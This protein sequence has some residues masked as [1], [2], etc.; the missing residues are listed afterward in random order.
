MNNNLNIKSQL[1][2]TGV[3]DIN[4]QIGTINEQLQELQNTK[5]DSKDIPVIQD[6][7]LGLNK[8]K[9]ALLNS[10]LE[11]D[12]AHQE[13]MALEAAKSSDKGLQ[14]IMVGGKS[15]LVPKSLAIGQSAYHKPEVQWVDENR[16]IDGKKVEGQR[17]PQTNEWKQRAQGQNISINMPSQ[18]ET[19]SIVQMVHDNGLDPT[20]IPK[21]GGVWNKAMTEWKKAY[22]NEN[23]N[24]YAAF[25]KWK[26]DT[27][28]NKSMTLLDSIEPMLVKMEQLHKEL[29]LS[30]FTDINKMKV[31]M[32]Q[33]TGDPKVAEY[34]TYMRNVVQELPPAMTGY[35]PTDTRINMELKNLE[36]QKSPAQIGASISAVR[37]LVRVRRQQFNSPSWSPLMKNQ[38]K[39]EVKRLTY[40]QTTGQLE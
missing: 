2:M 29:G 13:K 31:W 39:P 40:N 1:A 32:K 33:H 10:V 23:I 34:E 38:A 12:K 30:N 3:T 8:K 17:N 22:P 37:D 28:V 16:V 19:T 11:N 26:R 7:L 20:Q 25:S 9:T 15:V 21:R 5:P 35:F 4:T 24:D 6:K 36:A 18:E 27:S 14:E